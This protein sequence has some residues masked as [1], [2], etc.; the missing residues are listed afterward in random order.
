MLIEQ[1]RMSVM[2]C[3]LHNYAA[4]TLWVKHGFLFAGPQRIFGK[5]TF[6]FP[7][8]LLLVQ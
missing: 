3:Y 1:N 2:S 7:A 6:V 4:I 5:E 8:V